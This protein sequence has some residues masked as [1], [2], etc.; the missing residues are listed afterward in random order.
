MGNW[1]MLR[2]LSLTRNAFSGIPTLVKEFI[3]PDEV[4]SATLTSDIL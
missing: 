4:S 3:T 2:H 1:Q